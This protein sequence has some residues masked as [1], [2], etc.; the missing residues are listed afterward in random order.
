MSLNVHTSSEL[1]VAQDVINESIDDDLRAVECCR[2]AK[3]LE[4]RGEYDQAIAVLQDFWPQTSRRPALDGL[5][6]S[7][8]AEIL[9]RAGVLTS[10]LGNA[11]QEKKYR[12]K[13][14]NLLGSSLTIFEKLGLALMIAEVHVE[15]S[16]CYWVEG[17][18]DEAR[19]SLKL[20]L[21]LIP[22]HESNLLAV[23]LLRSAE[24]ER[25]TQHFQESIEILDRLRP[26]AALTNDNSLRG[27][28]HNNLA[29]TLKNIGE[30]GGGQHFIERSFV[31]YAQASC[32]F[33][34]SGNL[35]YQATVENNLG[36][37]YRTLGRFAEAHQHL[38]LA[39]NLFSQL[40]ENSF[41]AQVGETRSR[42]LIDEYR[43]AEAE[44]ASRAA[45]ETLTNADQ[46]SH[47]AEALT[48]RGVALSRLNRRGE[49]H[50][51]LNQAY[52]VAEGCRDRQAAARAMLTLLEE[53]FDDLSDK[54]RAEA[55]KCAARALA[56]SQDS[57]D[58][59]RLRKCEEI[60]RA[61]EEEK[62]R[63][64]VAEEEE[65]RRQAFYDS[66]TSLTNRR[67][68]NEL[69]CEVVEYAQK[70]EGYLFALLYIDL[71][72]VKQINDNY[73]HATGDQL[74]V[75]V[76][77]RLEGC[78]RLK[79]IVS[80]IGGDEFAILL[81]G[82]TKTEDAVL[83]AERIHN[84]LE[85]KFELDGHDVFTSASIGIAISSTGCESPD[86]VIR[87]ADTAMYCAKQ[88][89]LGRYEIFDREMHI[90]KLKTVHL[91]Q[92]LRGAIERQEF[93]L[94]YQPIV[95]L[96]TGR[97]AGFEAL[98]RWLHPEMGLIPPNDFI[99]VAEENGLILR[100]G[101]W[102]LWEACRQMREWQQMGLYSDKLMIS[103]NLSSKQLTQRDLVEQVQ[104]ILHQTNFDPTF[105]KLEITESAVTENEEVA[106]M[107]LRQLK[108]LG[109]QLSLDDF[110]TG[111]SSLNRL[112][113]Y[114]VTTLKIDKC[115]VS[116]IQSDEG[117]AFV[118]MIVTLAKT[119]GLDVVA[120][121]IE[122]AE[123][124]QLLSALKCEYGQ[125]YLLAKPL[126][127]SDAAELLKSDNYW[128]QQLPTTG[129]EIDGLLSKDLEQVALIPAT[130]TTL[131]FRRKST[132]ADVHYNHPN[133]SEKL[134]STNK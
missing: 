54:A 23:A 132:P 36:N 80:R 106:L 65:L 38:E 107:K 98:V 62:E 35:K 76:A 2:L 133:Q 81:R 125:G 64:R 74:L 18:Y 27:R 122:R 108:S 118:A 47:L 71:D 103:V 101:H 79:D 53:L 25:V 115:F 29:L 97:L 121:G 70:G 19:E 127:A 51:T 21:P 42:L 95:N 131:L 105:L 46:S 87:D 90:N 96:E 77:R 113:R 48:T 123:E 99:P 110:G 61:A 26:V 85:H 14:H 86:Q 73:G 92:E 100:I 45:V 116:E 44:R 57:N 32:F 128:E 10:W 22:E 28:Y 50:D 15:E 33:K 93:H 12:K 112:R 56:T 1:S 9:L 20:A 31:E 13:A 126:R 63:Q 91:E 16:W 58:L 40:K 117:R 39:Y 37:L 55:V 94:N 78:L 89:G 4:G 41:T 60:V 7:T 34:A 82:I 88:Q 66:L 134:R 67:R 69:L 43:Y 109:I 75:Q 8:A 84:A 111:Q 68:L 102:V 124:L 52:E 114:P 104:L 72:R 130:P 17:E 6:P 30:N 5:H 11:R 3:E 120:E 119:L 129:W 24:V 59:N 83:V 49:A